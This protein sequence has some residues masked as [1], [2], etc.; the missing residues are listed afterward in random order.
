MFGQPASTQAQ[1][2]GGTGLFGTSSNTQQQGGGLGM[3]GGSTLGQSNQQ[4]QQQQQP[5]RPLDQTLRFGQSTTEQQQQQNAQAMWEEGRGLGVY[6]SIPAQMNI[7]KDK[8]DAAT[9]SS[10]LRTYIYQHVADEKE[11]FMYRP[12]AS[13]DE[14]KWDEAISNRPGPTW[15]PLIIRGFWELG[16]K[17]QLQAEAMQRCNMILQEINNS[18]DMQLDIHRQKVAARLSEAKRRQG[19]ISRRTLA[20]AVKVQTLRNKGYVMDNAEEELRAQLEKLE[21]DVF[22]PSLEAREQE[23]WARMLGVR[24]RAKRLKTEMDKLTPAANAEEPTLDEST[25]K[26]AKTVCPHDPLNFDLC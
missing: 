6:R 12:D 26:S 14:N 15:V 1:T 21:R 4:Q 22:D 25:I 8:W 19:A 13:E 16:K 24:E 7:I 23:I 9:I 3:F 2:G 10:P 11:A 17:A 5:Q 20:L 18:L